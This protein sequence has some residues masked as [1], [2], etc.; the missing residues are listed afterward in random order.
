MDSYFWLICGVWC[1]V[2]GA[3]FMRFGLR[4][5]IAEGRI[6]AREAAGFTWG[7]ATWILL[8]CISLW[9][10]QRSAGSRASIAYTDWPNPQ[11]LIALALQAFI[12][13]T[14]LYWVFVK[15]GAEVLSRYARESQWPGMA[16]GPMGFKILVVVVGAAWAA[17][18]LTASA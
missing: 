11:R 7:T 2:F 17:S 16:P 3:A 4:K 10:L 8:P 15:N 14:L 12:Y 18:F 13:G 6:S 5:A 9:L 1:G